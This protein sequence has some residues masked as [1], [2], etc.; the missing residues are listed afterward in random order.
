MKKLVTTVLVSAFTALGLYADD[1][2]T[3]SYMGL[4]Y[5][6]LSEDEK[7][8]EVGSNVN[9]SGDV[10]IP[11]TVMNGDNEY[12]VT[13]IGTDAFYLNIPMTSISIPESVTVI[14]SQ[15]LSRCLGLKVVAIPN[16]VTE[17][18]SR[19]MYACNYLEHLTISSGLREIQRETFS[20]CPW[21]EEI[22]IPDGVEIIHD[23]AFNYCA[24]VTSL[25]IGST[26]RSIGVMSFAGLG[27]LTSVSIPASVETV[28]REAFSYCNKLAEVTI[29]EGGSPLSFD[30]DVFGQTQYLGT[31]DDPVAKIVTLNINRPF[32]CTS[33]DARLMPFAYKP[34]LTSINIGTTAPALPESAFA[35]CEAVE[36]V[37]CATT[38]CPVAYSSTFSNAAY[39]N[40]TLAVP[41]FY[42]EKYR[43]RTPWNKF[44]TIEGTLPEVPS[45]IES[46]GTEKNTDEAELY[47]LSGRRVTAPA[48]PGIYIL[49]HP[50]G[51]ATKTQL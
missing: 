46:V 33:S 29:E 17:M 14:R 6:V 51:S 27:A 32:T 22:V 8:C 3:F 16:S 31:Y 49:R 9:A 19:A 42:E 15:A 23:E 20:G 47:D 44:S 26:V 39:S 7:T 38:E 30:T 21:L 35:G 50:D 41:R 40:A 25:T 43:S 24:R 36:T 12:R 18:E 45:G 34:T 10:V 1:G 11:S 28:G 2:D 13:A 48:S 5:T 37:S 4:N